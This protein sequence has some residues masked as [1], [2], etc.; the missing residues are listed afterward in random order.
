MPVDCLLMLLLLLL[1]GEGVLEEVS[2][3]LVLYHRVSF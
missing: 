1:L 3:E 2:M